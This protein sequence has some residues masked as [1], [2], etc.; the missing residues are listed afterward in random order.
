M[1]ERVDPVLV[2]GAGPT[3][4][5][6]ANELVRHGVPVRIIDRAPAPATTS[7]ALVVMPRT[8]EIFDDMGVVDAALAAG[9]RAPGISLMFGGDKEG[10]T[11]TSVTC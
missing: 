9:N 10:A 8:L 6:M 5:T 11:W 3:G 2:V 7:R 1:T 4:L